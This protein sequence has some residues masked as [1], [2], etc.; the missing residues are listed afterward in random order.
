MT[1]N[2]YI[3]LLDGSSIKLN[4]MEIISMIREDKINQILD[5]SDVKL[6]PNDPNEILNV[7]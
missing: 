3:K 4:V 7:N 1:T 5:I 6:I 2:E